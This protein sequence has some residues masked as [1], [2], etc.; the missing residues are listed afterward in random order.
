MPQ[1]SVNQLVAALRQGAVIS[2]PTDT[3][4]ALAVQPEQA[5]KLFALKSRATTKPLILL[6]TS[7]QQLQPYVQ[8]NGQ[9]LHVWQQLSAQYWPGSLTLVLP[10]SALVPLAMHPETPHTIGIRVP[11]Q[12]LAL[13]LLQQT[14]PLATS[15]ANRSGEPP[16]LTMTAIATAFP[17][18]WVL[19][20]PNLDPHQ[21]VGS[22]Q[23]STVVEWQASGWQVLR[24]GSVTIPSTF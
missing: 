17:P 18:V 20:A 4:P 15:S 6:G 7:W 23:P 12:P 8:G 9:E 14:G 21:A 24:S 10:A 2:F 5:A 22:G 13:A 11:Q 19:A 3:V 1:A 16:L